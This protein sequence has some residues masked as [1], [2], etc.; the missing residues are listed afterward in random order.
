MFDRKQNGFSRVFMPSGKYMI[1]HWMNDMKH[2]HVK[3]VHPGHGIEE[4]EDL[5]LD[6]RVQ[7]FLF[8][9]DVP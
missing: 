8:E 5:L 4:G 9:N 7:V 2:G 6:N 1:G 3:I